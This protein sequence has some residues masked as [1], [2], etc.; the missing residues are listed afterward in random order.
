MDFFSFSIPALAW[1]SQS[2]TFSPQ[3]E[4]SARNMKLKEMKEIQKN[5]NSG[6]EKSQIH[7]IIF[8]VQKKTNLYFLTDVFKVQILHLTVF[9]K[10]LVALSINW[11]TSSFFSEVGRDFSD[12]SIICV[13]SSFFREG[14]RVLVVLSIICVTS[15]LFK[16]AGRALMVRES[17]LFDSLIIFFTSSKLEQNYIN[18]QY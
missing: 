2:F 6:H 3:L 15:S 4:V 5:I 17:S 10:L 16:P 7:H 14:G 8:K 13:T 18:I 1:S 11:M 9:K 12:F